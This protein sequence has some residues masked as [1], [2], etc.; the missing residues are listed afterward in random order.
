MNA[1]RTL[2]AW[3]LASLLGLS[4]AGCGSSG[5]P[6]ISEPSP[7]ASASVETTAQTTPTQASSN[8]T[9]A[10]TVTGTTS[11]QQGNQATVTVGVGT[12]Q[13][14]EQ[15]SNPVATAC[16]ATITNAGQS[17]G[18]AI[19]I[20]LRVTAELTSALKAP[21]GVDLNE[22]V[23][24]LD[25]HSH[26]IVQ[27]S[28]YPS[29][30]ELWS[31]VYGG[32]EPQCPTTAEAKW[33]AEVVTPH[34]PVTWEPWLVIANAITPDDPSGEAVID[35]ILIGPGAGVGSGKGNGALSPQGSGWVQCSADTSITGPESSP[36]LAVD[37]TAAAEQGCTT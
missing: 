11:D 25:P 6:T 7:P 12:P 9:F 16:D 4:P 29:Y 21:V 10:N 20:P 35:R 13:P 22:G 36:F 26:E 37:P 18:S 33:A 24:Y 5:E 2:A 15:V 19:A 1:T 8:S 32:S 28:N 14:L 31:A 23:Y 3:T 30:S 34:A 27:F 17:L